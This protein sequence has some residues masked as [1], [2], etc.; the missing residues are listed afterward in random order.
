MGTAERKLREKEQR[1]QNIL[2]I[3]E[4]LFFKRGIDLVTMDD[5]ARATELSKGTL[6][7]YFRNKEALFLA[8]NVRAKKQLREMM[9]NAL[10]ELATASDSH[11]LA[12]VMALG[13]AYITFATEYPDYYQMTLRCFTL[14]TTHLDQD[15]YADEAHYHGE[16]GFELLIRSLQTGQADGSIESSLNPG[17]TALVLWGQLNG[18]MQVLDVKGDYFQSKLNITAA[19]VVANCLELSS[20]M[21]SPR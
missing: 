6:Y 20:R 9:E 17:A 18:L 12:Q 2:D 15:R 7:L 5:L 10:Q 16:K 1:R 4:Q 8:I 11:G 14:E 3:A 19:A 21:I 13:R